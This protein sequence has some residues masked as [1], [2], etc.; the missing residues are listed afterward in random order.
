MVAAGERES[1]PSGEID[2]PEHAAFTCVHAARSSMCRIAR[3][4]AFGDSASTHRAL[5]VESKNPVERPER[6][7]A[8]GV[9]TRCSGSVAENIDLTRRGHQTAMG[10]RNWHAHETQPLDE[11]AFLAEAPGSPQRSRPLEE[12]IQALRRVFH[13]GRHLHIRD[14]CSAQSSGRPWC[15]N[16]YGVENCEETWLGD[17]MGHQ[18][19]IDLIFIQFSLEFLRAVTAL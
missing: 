6:D 12:S 8:A 3:F 5:T 1:Q 14:H 13:C 7:L 9:L 16:K 19:F 17:I 15:A 10:H 4:S 18:I 2:V 11:Q